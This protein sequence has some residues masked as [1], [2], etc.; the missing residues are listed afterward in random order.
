MLVAT[1]FILVVTG[2]AGRFG[3]TLT[4]LLTPLPLYAAVLGVF[5]HIHEGRASA[6]AVMHGLLVGLYG[7]GAFFL[8]LGLLLVPLGPWVAFAAAV[9]A[10]CLVQGTALLIA[11]RRP[12]RQ[13]AAE[14]S[15]G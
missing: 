9:A 4:G 6:T 3:P 14:S 13:P 2:L 11:R 7:F 10:V 15:S 5:A 12:R 8:V 1:A